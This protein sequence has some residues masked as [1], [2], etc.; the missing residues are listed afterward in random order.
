[1]V[2]LL[3]PFALM[4]YSGMGAI[5]RPHKDLV[6]SQ[7]LLA[8]KQGELEELAQIAEMASESVTVTDEKPAH[9]LGEQSIH[10]DDRLFG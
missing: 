5:V 7:K 10:D 8:K 4:A 9:N 2:A 3:L 6:T 1:M